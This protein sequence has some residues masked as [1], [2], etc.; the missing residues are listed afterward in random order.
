MNILLVAATAAEIG[1]LVE[2]LRLAPSRPG[3][4]LVGVFGEHRVEA[5]VTGVGSMATAYRLGRH[6]ADNYHD[7]VINLGVAG[8]FN[9]KLVPGKL[10]HVTVEQFADLGAE[11]GEKFLDLFDLELA[12]RDEFPFIDGRL[13]NPIDLGKHALAELPKARG[14][15]VNKVHGAAVSI[16]RIREQYPADVET[17]EGAAV[18]YVCI[19]E[20]QPFCQIRAISNK[21]EPRN[22]NAWKLREAVSNLNDYALELL[23]RLP[24]QIHKVEHR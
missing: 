6:L 17:M 19:C 9:E 4:N 12:G 10:C 8:S 24:A 1:P 20:K 16:E 21:I 22:R 13:A 14:L 23:A 7:L 5:L 18:F 11:D 2:R 15:T 3:S